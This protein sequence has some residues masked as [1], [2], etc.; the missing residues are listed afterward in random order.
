MIRCA[1][2]RSS[3]SRRKV[4]YLKNGTAGH[5]DQLWS[6]VCYRAGE[7]RRN[8]AA[9]LCGR[10][11][12]YIS[13]QRSRTDPRRIRARTWHDLHGSGDG[14]CNGHSER[15]NW[16]HCCFSRRTR[17]K[18]NSGG[19]SWNKRAGFVPGSCFTGFSCRLPIQQVN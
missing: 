3:R 19:K 17:R 1:F 14:R 5:C 8:A 11:H 10:L 7:P 6:K 16:R 4:I 9:R 2:V 13:R 18:G 12:A 15:T